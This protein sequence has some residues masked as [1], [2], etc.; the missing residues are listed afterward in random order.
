MEPE[1]IIQPKLSIFSNEKGS[2]AQSFEIND[3][4]LESR[5]EMWK[6]KLSVRQL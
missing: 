4:R 3:T 5:Q 6:K 1:I 2:K